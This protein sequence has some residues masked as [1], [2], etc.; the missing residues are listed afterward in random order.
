MLHGNLFEDWLLLGACEA[1]GE[2]DSAK[3]GEMTNGHYSPPEF[4][5]LLARKLSLPG[6]DQLPNTLA[7]LAAFRHI[8]NVAL[9][10]VRQ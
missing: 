8:F 6:S 3:R 9:R 5:S 7:L 10:R 2:K 1:R 4:L